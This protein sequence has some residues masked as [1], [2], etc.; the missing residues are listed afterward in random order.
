MSRDENYP[1]TGARGANLGRHAKF[2]LTLIYKNDFWVQRV[3]KDERRRV[4]INPTALLGVCEIDKI[5]TFLLTLIYRD[6]TFMALAHSTLDI[7]L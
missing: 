7:S 1:D 3:A 6:A 2:S 4:L 5:E